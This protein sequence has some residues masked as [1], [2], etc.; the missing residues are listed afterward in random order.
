MAGCLPMHFPVVVTA[1][2]A[3]MQDEF[4]MHGATASTGGCAVLV[5][6]NGPIRLE[7]GASG[8][9]N[10]LGNS[11]RATAVIGRAHA[12][13][14]DQPDGRA[15]GRHRPLDPRPSRQV[16]LLPGRG[17]GG[18]DLA[19][20][21][22]AA[23]HAER[24]ASAVTVMA[25]GAPRQIMNEWTTKPEE[26]LETFAAEM[27]ANLRH[28]SIHPGNYA[29]DHSQAAARASAGG[30]AGAR[31]TS[32]SFIHERARIHRREWA[33]VGKG[34]V[35]R[36]RGD[37]VYPA[38]ES[39]DQ[40][41]VIAAGGPAGG[42]GAIIPPWLG[43]K[44]HAVTCRSAPAS[45]ANRRRK[46]SEADH[47]VPCPRSH[48]RKRRRRSA[49]SRRACRRSKA[50]PSASSPTARRAPRASSAHLDQ[51]LREEHGVAKVV[52]RTKSNYSAPADAHIVAEIRNWDA[53]D[54]GH[55]RLRQLLIVQSARL[56]NG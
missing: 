18:H 25:A 13:L 48:R 35:V 56:R 34:A 36:D 22:R 42:F 55:W 28:Y 32:P 16:Q 5:V 26:I 50:R 29:I 12:A 47:D 37:S 40:L 46:R 53:V 10:A 8:T 38:M 15:A 6:L 33:E 41:L 24:E 44:S 7:L 54:L 52:S 39:P 49:S 4:L 1:W 2:T 30:E 43:N 31:P 45:I 11:D 51:M 9:F 20:A 3:M 21:V 23:R 27:R 17:R 19:A 14:P